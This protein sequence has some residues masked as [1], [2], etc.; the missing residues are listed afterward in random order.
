VIRISSSRGI[1]GSDRR[2]VTNNPGID[3]S[4]TWSPSGNSIVR[5]E[6]VKGAG[7]QIYL[8]DT[9]APTCAGS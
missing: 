8:C 5:I 6:Q 1:D 2:N 3:T 9:D 7:G 4:P